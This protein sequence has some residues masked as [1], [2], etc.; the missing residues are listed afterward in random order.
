MQCSALAVE[1]FKF[2]WYSDKKKYIE[3]F[4]HF[5]QPLAK[6]RQ[7][8]NGEKDKMTAEQLKKDTQNRLETI[9]H[10]RTRLDDLAEH[11]RQC[12]IGKSMNF[13]F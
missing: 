12:I 1:K 6:I 10:V 5:R 11:K 9:F 3:K 13:C 2:N 7:S 8:T 4:R